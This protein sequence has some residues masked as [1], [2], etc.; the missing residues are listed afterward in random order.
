MTT[1][2][3][4]KQL[5]EEFTYSYGDPRTHF[6][7]YLLSMPNSNYTLGTIPTKAAPNYFKY[8]CNSDHKRCFVPPKNLKK[9]LQKLTN[10]AKPLVIFPVLNINRLLCKQGNRSKHLTLVIYNTIT[11]EVERIDLRKYHVD[12]FT[13]KRF[14][15]LLKDSF[16][17][18]YIPDELATLNYDLDVPETFVRKHKFKTDSDAYP[19]F[20]MAY[21]HILNE[22]PSLERDSVMREVKK[23]SSKSIKEIWKTYTEYRLKR[24]VVL[25]DDTKRYF[26]ETNRCLKIKSM[27]P[28][29]LV[30]PTAVC[31]KKLVPHP[32]T[33]KCVKPESIK[34][35]DILDKLLIPKGKD[36][37]AIN[38]SNT[39]VIFKAMNYIIGLHKNVRYVHAPNAKTKQDSSITWNYDG[40]RF[41]L[42]YPDNIWSVWDTYMADSSVKFL[43]ILISTASFYTEKKNQGRHANL[44]IYD[45]DTNEMERFDSL[46]YHISPHYHMSELDALL[47][48]DFNQHTPTPIKYFTP[49]D[50]C[51]KVPIFQ[52]LELSNIPSENDTG[53]NCAVWRL[54]YIHVKLSNPHLNRKEL[55]ELANA[56]LQK[57]KSTAH[58]FIKAYQ[59]FIL[60]NV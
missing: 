46:G 28:L 7:E 11:S 35:V 14:V 24:E 43:I 36:A 4:S 34:D 38:V 26:P 31:K 45:K 40:E 23:L 19:L 2:F 21:L 6:L 33:N 55:I 9:V 8:T 32:L 53:G 49:L 10:P 37:A 50:Y 27:E 60:K 52:I 56:K 18:E 22:D 12:G 20:V 5:T 58:N 16:I 44:L 39:A 42:T 59:R 41:N 54:W 51:P 15:N 30:E 57:G 13:V 29:L 47:V 17:T 48:P 25:C 1:S 3:G